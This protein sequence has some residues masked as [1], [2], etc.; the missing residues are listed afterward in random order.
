MAFTVGAAADFTDLLEQVVGFVTTDAGLV[1]SGEAWTCVSRGADLKLCVAS[2]E[3]RNASLYLKEN[4]LN[5]DATTAWLDV[6]TSGGW[7]AV[8]LTAAKAVTEM[9]LLAPNS[10]S[11]FFDELP[12]AF[13]LQS[14]DDGSTWADELTISG[15]SW[16]FDEEKSWSVTPS[17]PHSWWRIVID[18]NNGSAEWHGLVNWRLFDAGGELDVRAEAEEVLRGPGIAGDQEIYFGLRRDYDAAADWF[19]LQLRGGSGYVAGQGLIGPSGAKNLMLWD[20]T[21]PYWCVANGQRVVLVAKVSTT[22]HS[23]H[24]GYLLA[25]GTPGQYP[26]PMYIGASDFTAGRRWSST[27]HDTRFFVAPG[28]AGGALRLQDGTWQDIENFYSSSSSRNDYSVNPHS[29]GLMDNMR[30]NLDGGYTLLP[31]VVHKKTPPAAFGELDGVRAVG[32]FGL[33]AEDIIQAG[34]DDWLVVQNVF[35]TEAEDY[36]AVRLD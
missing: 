32:G 4:G 5:N 24:A 1:G 11:V 34:G 29:S 6:G 26:Y 30:E 36:M 28:D 20:Q 33:A 22:Y 9:R 17:G 3:Y 13:R 18:A 15:L 19:N 14:S 2:G 12:T 35:R 8:A 7:L 25:Y 10:A 21:I 27:D 23:L 16:A 31:C